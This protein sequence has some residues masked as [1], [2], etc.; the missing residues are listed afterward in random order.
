MVMN[1]DKC[2]GCHTC[3]ITCKNAWTNRPGAEYMYFNNV[4]TKPGIGYPKNW[5]NQEKW[6]GGWT[7]KNASLELATGSKT[8]RLLKLFYHPQQPELDDYY[9]P[10]TYDYE[11]LIHAG[12][13]NHQPIARPRSLITKKRMEI[14]WG[15]NWEDDLAGGETARSDYN[16]MKMSENAEVDKKIKMD[17]EDLF[18]KYLPRL[19]NHCTNPACVAACPSGAIYKRDED[20][21]VLVSQDVCRGWRHCVPSC[22]YKKIYYNWETNKAE[23][24][25]FCYPRIEN[26]LPSI[27]SDTC[28]GR[29]RY[30]GVLLYD[31]EKVEMVASVQDKTKIYDGMLSI[32]LDPNDADVKKEA[33]EQGISENVLRAAAHSP[34]YKLVKEWQVALPLHPEYRTLPMVWYVPPLS[35][36]IQ[37]KAADI[38]FPDPEEMRIPLDYLG[39]LF[40]AGNVEI[41]KQTIQKLL[42]MRT[43]MQCKLY[44]ETPTNIASGLTAET[45]EAMYRLLAIAKYKDR[46]VIPAGPNLSLDEK[47]SMQGGAGFTCPNGGGSL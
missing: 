10:W 28:V 29:M 8:N 41:I 46:F 5:E 2:I 27:C 47:R 23:K 45:L 19:C 14:T 7:I 6:Q 11:T 40:T 25:T 4:E 13:K 39:E 15:P 30:M 42:D 22:P 18:M 43:Y 36:I 35:P 3:S 37:N 34:V 33:I 21:I 17:F 16:L 9:E 20:G 12:K 26:G 31:M 24:C 1:L 44:G 32:L 38:S